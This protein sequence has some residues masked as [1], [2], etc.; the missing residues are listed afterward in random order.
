MDPAGL[1]DQPAGNTPDPAL[2]GRTRVDLLLDQLE[3]T[4]D[5]LIQESANPAMSLV[6]GSR[7]IEWTQ[8]LEQTGNKL[9]VPEQRLVGLMQTAG[10][11]T[12]NPISLFSS[13]EKFLVALLQISH[14]EAKD[15]VRAAR[16]FNEQVA[17]SGQ[18]IPVRYPALAVEQQTGTISTQRIGL[19][20]DALADWERL[21]TLPGG[22][23]TDHAVASAE[24]TLADHAPVLPPSELKRVIDRIG[25]YLNP[26]GDYTDP[27]LH[28]ELRSLKL[29]LIRRGLHRGQWRLEGYLTPAVGAQTN[30][31]LGSLAKPAPVKDEHGHLLEPDRRPPDARMHDAFAHL[32]DHALR[33][34]DLPAHGGTPATLIIRADA[35]D[36]LGQ[37]TG[38][39]SAADRAG[40]GTCE[41]GTRLPIQDVKALT[42]EAEIIRLIFAKEKPEPLYLGRTR[43]LATHAQTMALVARDKGCTFPGCD[44]SPKWCQ[45]HHLIDWLHGGKTDL[46][47]L[48]LLCAYHH[49]R[50]AEHGWTADLKHGRVWWKPPKTIDTEQKPILNEHHFPRLRR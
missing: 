49:Y 22:P 13:M 50:F 3:Q 21:Q 10:C 44:K 1:N 25:D 14:R 46:D 37:I 48:T 12:D 16:M 23:I 47:N 17:P 18:R 28:D 20:T 15:R 27:A 29:S 33:S 41:D 31:A 9:A 19:I 6:K 38:A 8:R 5:L 26:D 24:A 36:L 2:V 34:P 45:R 4:V 39:N 30:A 40:F 42:G 43:R 35:N 7:L 11:H 32:L